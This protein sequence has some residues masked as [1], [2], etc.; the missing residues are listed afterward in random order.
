MNTLLPLTTETPTAPPSCLFPLE[1]IILVIILF[2]DTDCVPISLTL[3]PAFPF[4]DVLIA[5]AGIFPTFPTSLSAVP[6]PLKNNK[7]PPILPI[8]SVGLIL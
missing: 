6:V 7:V 8:A 3:V 5:L 1:K 2:P 4:N